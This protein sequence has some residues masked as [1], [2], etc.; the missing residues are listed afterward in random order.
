VRLAS[1]GA[2]VLR[3]IGEEPSKGNH[4]LSSK[5]M[6][7]SK[8]T[9]KKPGVDDSLRLVIDTT[10]LFPQSSSPTD[11]THRVSC[12][13][14]QTSRWYVQD[15]IM[16]N[17]CVLARPELKIRKSLRLQVIQLIKNHTSRL[18]HHVCRSYN[19]PTTIFSWGV[20][21]L[22]VP[23]KLALAISGTSPGLEKPRS[24]NS[25]EFL[26]IVAPHLT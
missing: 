18:L 1:S 22:P 6:T 12:G 7:T 14:C 20:L 5:R 9:Q 17:S 24:F 8:A 2:R 10:C 15:P 21:T 4:T 25:R 23:T 26:D 13:N 16:E 3:A 11:A 19:D